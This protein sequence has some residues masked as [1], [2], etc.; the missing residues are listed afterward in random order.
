L[1]CAKYGFVSGQYH[2]KWGGWVVE[3][4]GGLLAEVFPGI[5][6]VEFASNIVYESRVVITQTMLDTGGI[7]QPT[8]FN[9]SHKSIWGR[10]TNLCHSSMDKSHPGAIHGYYIPFFQACYHVKD[11][12][13]HLILSIFTPFLP[14]FHGKIAWNHELHD[15]S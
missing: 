8:A 4:L 3:D 6:D 13:Q 15:Q 7:S 5:I 11:V 10:A 2:G 1:H 14:V 9:G 12:C